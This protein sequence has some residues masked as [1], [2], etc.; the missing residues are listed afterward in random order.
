MSAYEDAL[1]N[2]SAAITS[3][4]A[5]TPHKDDM[6]SLVP[7]LVPGEWVTAE[8]PLT[9]FLSEAAKTSP[10]PEL[11]AVAVA[12]GKVRDAAWATYGAEHV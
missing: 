10:T 2:L 1:D 8:Y 4:P 3:L 11:N 12:V 7:L 5:G 6:V 9:H